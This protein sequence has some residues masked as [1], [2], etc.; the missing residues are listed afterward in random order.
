[1]QATGEKKMCVFQMAETGLSYHRGKREGEDDDVEGRDTRRKELA[2]LKGKGGSN[3]NGPMPTVQYL[4]RAQGR[5]R[6]DS[7]VS[8]GTGNRGRDKRREIKG[9]A[10]KTGGRRFKLGGKGKERGVKG[11][12]GNMQR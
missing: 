2:H 1:M 10:L 11:N 12:N 8:G 6:E 7:D 9:K 4:Y 5:T 3:R